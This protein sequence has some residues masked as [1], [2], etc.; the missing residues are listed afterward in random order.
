MPAPKQVALRRAELGWQAALVGAAAL[1]L[2]AY[3]V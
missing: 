2:E 1:A 3:S